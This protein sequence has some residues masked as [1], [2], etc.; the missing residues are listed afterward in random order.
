MIEKSKKETN[1]LV[2]YIYTDTHRWSSLWELHFYCT[3]QSSIVRVI[4]AQPRHVNVI[5]SLWLLFVYLFYMFV[6]ASG[7]LAS[8]LLLKLVK[9]HGLFLT[10]ALACGIHFKNWSTIPISLVWN[11]S[12][13]NNNKSINFLNAIRSQKPWMALAFVI[14]CFT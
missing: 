4:A 9:V 13:W 10:Q 7:K 5:F 3:V 8:L 14:Q 1:Q 11:L 2:Y 12:F 6:N